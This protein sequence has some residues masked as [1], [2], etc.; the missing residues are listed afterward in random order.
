MA[1]YKDIHKLLITKIYSTLEDMSVDVVSL[2]PDNTAY[3]FV[4][5]GAIT[6]FDFGNKC[7]FITEG[8]IDIEIHTGSSGW[9]GSLEPLYDI[10]EEVKSLLQPVK[11]QPI[12][13]G[14]SHEMHKWKIQS[15]TGL[16]TYDETNRLMSETITYEFSIVQKISYKTRVEND[17]GTVED[18]NCVPLLYK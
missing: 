1:F 16:V 17:E 5:I 2:L 11:G 6:A 4:Y 14:V 15:D 10:A 9:S 13:L 7:D 8:T 18:S 3:P 12:D